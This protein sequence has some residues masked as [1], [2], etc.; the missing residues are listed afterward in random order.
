MKTK[1]IDKLFV[2][3]LIGCMSGT[4]LYIIIAWYIAVVDNFDLSGDIVGYAVW[5]SWMTIMS[6][7]AFKVIEVED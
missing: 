6:I 5:F 3:I 7:M 4:F 1:L 2:S